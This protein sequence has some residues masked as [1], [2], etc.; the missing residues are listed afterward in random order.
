MGRVAIRQ[1]GVEAVAR[2]GT[3]FDRIFAIHSVDFWPDPPARLAELR[4]RL[5]VGGR[6][7]IT[8]QPRS[9]GANEE[10]VRRVEEK[11]RRWLEG[12]GLRDVRAERLPLSP[13]AAVCAMGER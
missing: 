11:L 8:V 4:D 12:A 13:V 9:A 7:A 2:E 5:S 3:R 1:A 6:L 10:T